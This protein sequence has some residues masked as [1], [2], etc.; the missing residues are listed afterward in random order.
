MPAYAP[1]L[2]SFGIAQTDFLDFIVTLN[3]SLE[4]NPY[5]NGINLAEFA[6]QASP[7]PISSLLIGVGV[8][9]VTDA[10][11]KTQ[12]RVKSNNLLEKVNEE[13]FVPRGL[14]AFVGTWRPNNDASDEFRGVRI[15]DNTTIA[16]SE[17]DIKST[18]KSI[19]TGEMSATHVW[20][21]L[22]Q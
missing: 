5:L 6:G 7:E 18:D 4:P 12:S 1:T 17:I 21:D 16:R 15:N 20:R 11:M 2:S 9:V 3:A 8:K 19:V 22:Q 14:V 13:F 10:I